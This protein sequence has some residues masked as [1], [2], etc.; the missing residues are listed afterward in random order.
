MKKG[1]HGVFEDWPK[2][3]RATALLL[4]P[5]DWNFWIFL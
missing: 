2:R 5:G 3:K 4:S 1:K